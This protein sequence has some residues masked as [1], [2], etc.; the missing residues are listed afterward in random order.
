MVTITDA[1]SHILFFD[2]EGLIFELHSEEYAA[3]SPTTLEVI[4]NTSLNRSFMG[5]ATNVRIG[6]LGTRIDYIGSWNH[7][8]YRR[9]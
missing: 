9:Q 4:S 2:I 8:A 3:M 7:T 5:N 6:V 1:E